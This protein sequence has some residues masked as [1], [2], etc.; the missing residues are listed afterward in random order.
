MYS[1]PQVMRM[2]GLGKKGIE[3]LLNNYILLSP[4]NGVSYWDIC[5]PHALNKELNGGCFD[6]NNIELTY[7]C[8]SLDTKINTFFVMSNS[9]ENV[10][11]LNS[12]IKSNHIFTV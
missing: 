2:P 6:V 10:K 11:A 8:N 3:V 9:Q 7:P 4:G 5:A 1:N 12:K